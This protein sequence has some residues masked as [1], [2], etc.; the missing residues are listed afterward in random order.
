MTEVLAKNLFF[1]KEHVGMFKASNN[2][3]IYDPET[4]EMFMTCREENLGFF[5]KLLRFTDYKRMTPFNIEIRTASGEKVLTVKR[6]ISIFLSTVEVFDAN[7]QLIGMFKQKFFSI[8]GK[9]SVLDAQENELCKLK[10]KW[11][12]WDFKFVKD[13]VQFAHVSKEWAGLGKELFTT[14]DNYMLEIDANIPA[15]HPIRQ[16]ILAAVM[17]IDMVLKE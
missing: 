1:I 2:Y 14:A 12:S 6:G 4:N 5:T 15:D 9:F 11:T 3:D 8:G 10:G 17:C 16:L 7:D 13:D